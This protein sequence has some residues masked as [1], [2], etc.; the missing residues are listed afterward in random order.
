VAENLRHQFIAKLENRFLKYFSNQLTYRYLER[1]STGKY[2]LLD[3]K[4]TFK[5]G[6]FETYLLVN[7]LTNTDYTEVFGVPMPGR[8]FHL[9]VAFTLK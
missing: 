8:W 3:E 4:L 7:N 5:K 9:G 2:Q 1:V 6:N